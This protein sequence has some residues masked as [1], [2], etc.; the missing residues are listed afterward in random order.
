MPA[1][2]M[3]TAVV[4]EVGPRENNE[5]SVWVSP[6][7]V[8][9]ADGVGG[10]IA[11]EIASGLAIRK[12]SALSSRRIEHPLSLEL[13]AAV[14]VPAAALRFLP[15]TRATRAAAR[16]DQRHDQAGGRRSPL[17]AWAEPRTA[18]VQIF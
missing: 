14:A 6:R 9:V 10:A 5:D 16:Q 13:S 15:A 4:S 2:T 17:Q 8:A 7:L 1:L 12:M 11:G 18:G 3:Q